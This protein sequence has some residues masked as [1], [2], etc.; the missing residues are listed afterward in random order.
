MFFKRKNNKDKVPA[1]TEKDISKDNRKILI[2]G[3]KLKKKGINSF[4]WYEIPDDLNLAD[5]DVV[6][7]D[8]SVIDKDPFP[9]VGNIEFKNHWN[10]IF[11]CDAKVLII[12]T[13]KSIHM[14]GESGSPYGSFFSPLY[15]LPCTPEWTDIKGNKIKEIDNKY[16][17]YFKHVKEWFFHF[18]Y[19][20]FPLEKFRLEMIRQ[21][22]KIQISDIKITYTEIAKNGYNKPISCVFLFNAIDNNDNQNIRSCPVIW[23]PPVSDD[24]DKI[25]YEILDNLFEFEDYIEKPKWIN[26]YFLTSMKNIIESINEIDS[27][28]NKLI[29][30]KR[31]KIIELEKRTRFTKL[32]YEQ[33]SN[34][35]IIVSD[36]LKE[37]DCIILN[38]TIG[39]NEDI[40]F[41]D[42][43]GN[44]WIVEVKGRKGCLKRDDIRQLDDWVKKLILEENWQGYAL[45]I[46]NYFNEDIPSNRKSP[47]TDNEKNTLQR[48][49]FS[50]LT[51]YELF[52]VIQQKENSKYDS[53][54]YWDF[55]SK[56]SKYFK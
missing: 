7:I 54:N 3:H 46:G 13:P 35:E 39:N 1:Q 56:K 30:N 49:G 34:L 31:E 22:L 50:L 42:P 45:L 27:K 10:L 16:Q 38:K 24:K 47:L 44:N 17:F 43:N 28:I 4:N 32:L 36:A 33:G 23:L 20:Y 19:M 53:K 11:N 25:I 21:S 51:T 14:K 12:G 5:Y 26:N 9:E 29:E 37:L 8:F 15:L 2:I 48:F 6:L 52:Q 40:Q 18:D 55:I 41:K